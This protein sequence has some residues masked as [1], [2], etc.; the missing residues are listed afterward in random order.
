M[1]QSGSLSTGGGPGEVFSVTGTVH[2]IFASPTTGN[3]VVSLTNGVSLGSYQ[4]TIPPPGGLIVPGQVG[5]ATNSPDGRTLLDVFS[6]TTFPYAITVSGKQEQPDGTG[7]I[8]SIT[9]QNI[10]VPNKTNDS[11]FAFSSFS[12]FGA[13]LGDT[14]ILAAGFYGD[15]NSDFNLGTINASAVFYA[16]AGSS[17]VA[18]VTNSYGGYF[19]DQNNISAT[20]H[21]GLYTD[22]AAIGSDS[23]QPPAAGL[24]VAGNIQNATLVATSLVG[25]DAF[26]NLASVDDG[27]V[28]QVLTSNG[29]G[30]IPSFQN[31]P[32]LSLTINQQTFLTA[33]TFTYTPSAGL[34]YAFVQVLG[35]GAGGG[36]ATNSGANDVCA[37]GGGGAGGYA[38]GYVSAAFI[39]V[40]Q[41]VVVG[42]GGAGGSSA[43]GG[44]GNL[45]A[46]GVAPLLQGNGGSGGTIGTAGNGF[47]AGGGGGGFGGAFA[48]YGFAGETGGNSGPPSGV[49]PGDIPPY[50]FGGYGASAFTGYQTEG[51]GW[52]TLTGAASF[53][54]E[55]STEYGCAGAGGLSAISSA[56]ASGG[57]GFSGFVIVTEYI[58]S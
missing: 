2:Q 28:N 23:V 29:P 18:T 53:P 50:G 8:S 26:S 58:L 35:G 56:P 33:G 7:I 16:D 42:T 55:T 38:E 40:S 3:V 20:V 6:S 34:A 30:V 43:N 51:P 21:M 52:S 13:Q 12:S 41:T 19:K 37:A 39:G 57:S 31:L 47:Q 17:F 11:C 46:F 49:A 32:S 10:L 25:T 24:Y 14:V 15:F 54:G 5:I 27:V 9:T 4:P 44:D 48:L 1:S 22:T 36:G 45:S